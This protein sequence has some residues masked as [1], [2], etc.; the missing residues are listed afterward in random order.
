MPGVYAL[1]KSVS[2]TLRGRRVAVF[3]ILNHVEGSPGE[4]AVGHRIAAFDPALR[5][6]IL[7]V[8]QNDGWM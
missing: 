5:A 7:P 8:G 6:G 4:A 1:L 3:I 2:L